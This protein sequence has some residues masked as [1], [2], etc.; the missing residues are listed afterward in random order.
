M[1]PCM[2]TSFVWDDQAQIIR[3][4]VT[5]PADSSAFHHNLTSFLCSGMAPSNA[6]LLLNLHGMDF[7]SL[8]PERAA[9]LADLRQKT[10]EMRRGSCTAMLVRGEIE[11]LLAR[12]LR[13]RLARSGPPVEIFTE[14]SQ[15]LDWIRCHRTST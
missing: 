3:G 9:M 5:G 1:G 6:P 15:A 13:E 2:E 4:K 10:A 12:Y 8:T 11:L 7:S 14:E